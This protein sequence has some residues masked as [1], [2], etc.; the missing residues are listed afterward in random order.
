MME[1]IAEASPR[2]KARV[3]GVLYFFSLLTAGFTEKFVHGRL[4]YAGGYIAIL[5]MA[6][7]T[8]IFYDILKPVNRSLSLLAVFV[9]FVGLTF[10]ALRLQPQGLNI[11]LVFHGFYCILVGYLIFRSTFLPRILG[12]LMAFAGLAW[13][14]FLSNPLVNY[15]SPYNLVSGLLGDVSVFLWLLVMGVNA[16]RWKEQ[17]GTVGASI[18]T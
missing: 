4:N 7:M 1:R 8:L 17:A 10:E 3:A 2:F 15:L 5:G 16:Q 12:M 9:A 18:R 6:A 11:A 13:L 14:T